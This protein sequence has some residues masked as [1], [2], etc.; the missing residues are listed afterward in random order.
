MKY[1]ILC[2][3]VLFSFNLMAQTRFWGVD[4]NDL[5]C[6]KN[7][8]F[9]C[10]DIYRN[11]YTGIGFSKYSNGNLWVVQTFKD[12]KLDGNTK[13]YFE[14]GNLKID[15][16]YVDGKLDGPRKIYYENGNLLEEGNYKEGKPV[17]NWRFYTEEG[18]LAKEG[19]V[20]EDKRSKDTK[21][22]TTIGKLFFSLMY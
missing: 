19:Y 20:S 5:R 18:R 6:N 16:N 4:M 17:G 3:M 14:N 13:V 10:E 8:G 7:K 9:Y 2:F 12:G 22:L 11:P 21:I 1:V 15:E